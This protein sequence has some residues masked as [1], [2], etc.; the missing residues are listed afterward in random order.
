MRVYSSRKKAGPH[1]GI[2]GAIL[3]FVLCQILG[4]FGGHHGPG[5]VQRPRLGT[6]LLLYQTSDNGFMGL[7]CL[8]STGTGG[9]RSTMIQNKTVP[10]LKCV[11]VGPAVQEDGSKYEE[12]T[13]TATPLK[14]STLVNSPSA[15]E[16]RAVP[17]TFTTI[18]MVTLENPNASHNP[19]TPEAPK[20]QRSN[21]AFWGGSTV[22]SDR[23]VGVPDR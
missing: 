11:I 2:L 7:S 4:D 3:P 15:E 20:K 18:S 10:W 17:R 21:R 22:Q 8:L 1:H 13:K 14:K 23:G 16:D 12:S 5:L 6:A 9:P 19:G